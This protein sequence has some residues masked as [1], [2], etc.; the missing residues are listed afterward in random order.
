M[1]FV[2]SHAS[3]H[4]EERCE[5]LQE[6]IHQLRCEI[7]KLTGRDEAIVARKTFGLTEA[8]SFIFMMLV[9][10][11]RATYAQLQGS[12]YTDGRLEEIDDPDWAI[13]S[14]MKRIRLKT[15]PFGVDFGTIYSYGY[16]MDEETRLIVRTLMKNVNV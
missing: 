5:V 15:R 3:R 9:K 1:N 10:C 8:E 6:E 2:Q 4:W 14:H 13:R 12:V 11:G 7:A 16:E